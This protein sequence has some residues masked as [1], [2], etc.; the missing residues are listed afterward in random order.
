MLA[1]N[2]VN[3]ID[4]AVLDRMNELVEVPLPTLSER[5]LLLRNYLISHV[6]TPG[7][8]QNNRVVLDKGVISEFE[9]IYTSLA[10]STEGM[11]GREIEK[12]C[13]NIFVSLNFF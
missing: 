8:D 3:Q 1:T 9:D 2:Q 12:M 13:S 10:Q 7:E 5:E 11:S 6:L 4:S